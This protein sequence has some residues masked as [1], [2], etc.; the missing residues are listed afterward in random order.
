M[1]SQLVDELDKNTMGPNGQAG[2]PYKEARNQY[3]GDLDVMDS[4]RAGRETFPKLT[5]DDVRQY[6]WR[7]SIIARA[8]H[9]A[10]AWQ[11]VSSSRSLR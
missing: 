4:L 6:E 7:S 9:S 2:S 5:A 1:R 3:A 10:R 11:R 8:M